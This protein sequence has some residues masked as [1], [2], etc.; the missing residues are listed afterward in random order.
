MSLGLCM[1]IL[2]MIAL[3]YKKYSSV[4]LTLEGRNFI[5]L[6][7]QIFPS[8]VKVYSGSTNLIHTG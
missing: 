7:V 6:E 5:F 2:I 4:V 1:S 8:L 3:M